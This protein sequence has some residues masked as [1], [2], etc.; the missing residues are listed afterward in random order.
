MMSIITMRALPALPTVLAWLQVLDLVTTLTIPD[1]LS[2][3]P[4]ITALGS[5]FD[6]TTLNQSASLFVG[7]LPVCDGNFGTK[8]KQTSC[9]NAWQKIPRNKTEVTF[10]TRQ[11]VLTEDTPLPVRYLSDDGLCAI[12]LFDVLELSQGNLEDK[13][14]SFTISEMAGVILTKCAIQQGIGGRI[15]IQSRSAHDVP[16]PYLSG[17]EKT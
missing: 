15:R 14:D 12:D 10:R 2:L 5:D 3:S 1:S 17:K 13:T 7:F 9:I 6:G 16:L 4:N 8:L 11:G